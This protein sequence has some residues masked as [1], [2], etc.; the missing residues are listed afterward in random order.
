MK[1]GRIETGRERERVLR[2]KKMRE[3]RAREGGER[4]WQKKE[5]EIQWKE[6]TCVY[7]YSSGSIRL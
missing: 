5:T 7:I 2:E 4:A 6:S 3:M 1:E